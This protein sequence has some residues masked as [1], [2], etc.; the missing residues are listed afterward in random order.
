MNCTNC[1]ATLSE[2]SNICEFCGTKHDLDLLIRNPAGS[3]D[4]FVKEKHASG[5]GNIDETTNEES[6][7][8]L[9][10]ELR[11]G[12]KHY[13][14]NRIKDNL[15]AVYM[16]AILIVV[17]MIPIFFYQHYKTEY[18]NKGMEQFKKGI[19]I[20]YDNGKQIGAIHSF[21]QSISAVTNNNKI[22]CL[23]GIAS[24]Y[25]YLNHTI[26]KGIVNKDP[27]CAGPLYEDLTSMEENLK[28][29]IKLNYN[30]PEAHY[31]IGLYYI[32]IHQYD[33]ALTEFEET[34]NI[35]GNSW[36]YNK[37]KKDK[38]IKASELMKEI[39][40]SIISGKDTAYAGIMPPV[41]AEFNYNNFKL[42]KNPDGTGTIITGQNEQLKN[43]ICPP[44]PDEA[45]IFNQKEK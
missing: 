35:A 34:I 4:T 44:M 8:K 41:I 10:G 1:G 5:E 24:Y 28:K 38:W 31:Y 19:Y 25:D 6:L 42:V 3:S 9:W 30:N 26:G 17:I 11:A 29:A 21:S 36:K 32:R 22:H 23:I 18:Y 45:E 13:W 15:I 33:R 16:L 7:H 27:I 2:N 14:K 43:M 37:T 12:E 20:Y 40:F 39:T